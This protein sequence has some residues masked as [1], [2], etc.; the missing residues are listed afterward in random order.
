MCISIHKQVSKEFP[1]LVNSPLHIQ[2]L[3]PIWHYDPLFKSHICKSVQDGSLWFGKIGYLELKSS[4]CIEKPVTFPDL[5]PGLKFYA[6]LNT[7]IG[8]KTYILNTGIIVN[9]IHILRNNHV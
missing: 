2:I 8:E 9:L 5:S 1:H 6:M 4:N 3:S 7:S